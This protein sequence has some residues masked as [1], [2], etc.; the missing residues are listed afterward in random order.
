MN[1]KITAKTPVETNIIKTPLEISI[2]VG[3]IQIVHL[4]T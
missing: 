3:I 1:L 4:N 2:M